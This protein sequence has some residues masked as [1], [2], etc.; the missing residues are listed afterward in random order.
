MKNLPFPEKTSDSIFYHFFQDTEINFQ[1]LTLFSESGSPDSIYFIYSH[2]N[3]LLGSFLPLLSTP[4]PHLPR[5]QAETVLPLS[6]IL[7]RRRHKPNKEDKA[8]LLVEI[9]IAI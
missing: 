5:F 4:T 7:F 3:T 1:K 8:F 9:R 2:V 6:L